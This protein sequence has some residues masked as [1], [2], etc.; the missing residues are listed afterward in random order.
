M[1]GNL[2]EE[3]LKILNNSQICHYPKITTYPPVITECIT[4]ILINRV[5]N[6]KI[7]SFSILI[8][9][10]RF[11]FWNEKIPKSQSQEQVECDNQPCQWI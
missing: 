11:A 6:L 8:C 1:I 7:Y 5:R 4:G 10:C 3:L 9:L 2:V